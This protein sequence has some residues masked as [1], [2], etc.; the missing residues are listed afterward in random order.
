MKPE[1][2]SEN[3]GYAIRFGVPEDVE[4]YYIQGFGTFDPEIARLTGSKPYYSREEVI[5]FFMHSLTDQSRRF[6]LIVDPDGKIIG[7]S[8][9]N[10]IEWDVRC[11]N[12]RICLFHPEK[13]GIGIGTWVTT[14][15]RDYAFEVLHLH[16]LELD[17]FSFNPRAKAVYEKA[18]FRVEGVRREAIWDGE[19][20]ADDILMAILEDEWKA[21]KA[22]D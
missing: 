9:I 14:F 13:L 3:D 5:P 15:T 18:G 7:E 21:I 8:V 2:L 20:Y 19:K 22:E 17:V 11:A 10:E 6:F 12:F 1:I 4:N 16:R